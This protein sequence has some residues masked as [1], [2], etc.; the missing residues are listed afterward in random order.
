VRDSQGQLVANALVALYT[1]AGGITTAIDQG[2]T[3]RQGQITIYGAVAGSTIRASTFNAALAGAVTVGNEAGYELTLNPTSAGRLTAQ[4]SAGTPYLN[5]VPG[6]D[7]STLALEV[8]GAAAGGN[9]IGVVI[10][11][12]GGSS[13]KQAPLAYSPG[14]EAYTGQVSFSGVEVGSGAV[15]VSGLAGTQVIAMNSDYNLQRVRVIT[16]NNLYAEDGNFELHLTPG[17]IPADGYATI[18]P[19]GYVPGPL[20]EGKQVIGSAYQVRLSGALVELD[21][22][23]L[24]RLHYHPAVMGVYTDTAIYYWDAGN[25]IWQKRGG[26]PSEIDNALSVPVTRLGIYALMGVAAPEVV[27]LPVIVK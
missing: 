10:P 18:L 14:V 22:E 23:G 12:A 20:P 16:A 5:L 11:D 8:H 3:D 24:V 17:S 13:P 1:T 6:S 19:T 27:Y 15:Q 2:L 21:Q 9:L 4:A 26:E 25:E 7:G